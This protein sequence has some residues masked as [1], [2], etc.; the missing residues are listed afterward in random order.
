[1]P[2]LKAGHLSVCMIVEK[3]LFVSETIECFKSATHGGMACRL[4]R[5][6]VREAVACSLMSLLAG[7]KERLTHLNALQNTRNSFILPN[8][9][10]LRNATV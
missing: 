7:Y 3:S 4:C 9:Q 1:V 6:L 5:L 10:A 2:L 8:P